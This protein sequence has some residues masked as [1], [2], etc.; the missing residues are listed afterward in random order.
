MLSAW[1]KC[2]GVNPSGSN[3]KRK[4][5]QMETTGVD[6]HHFQAGTRLESGPGG[7]W[8]LSARAQPSRFGAE[9][10]RRGGATQTP[11]GSPQPGLIRLRLLLFTRGLWRFPKPGPDAAV[12]SPHPR[13][14]VPSRRRLWS[15]GG[16]LRAASSCT[17]SVCPVTPRRSAPS[18]CRRGRAACLRPAATALSLCL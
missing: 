6:T 16:D 15:R 10:R 9:R 1:G 11:P 5:K 7:L 12:P 17:W 14:P 18:G 13:G 3:V 8:C 2:A 4:T